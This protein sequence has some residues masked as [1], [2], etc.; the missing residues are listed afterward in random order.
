M[1][2]LTHMGLVHSYT[3]NFN[4]YL[5]NHAHNTL[6]Y[7]FTGPMPADLDSIPMEMQTDYTKFAQASIAMSQI[8]GNPDFSSDKINFDYSNVLNYVAVKTHKFFPALNKWVLSHSVLTQSRTH[9]GVENWVKNVEPGD[10]LGDTTDGLMRCQSWEVQEMRDV[11]AMDV[12]RYSPSQQ[13][14]RSNNFN[15]MLSRYP[16]RYP[17]VFI[18]D[19]PTT[20]DSMLI[21]PGSN[22]SGYMSAHY[23]FQYW[24]EVNQVWVDMERLSITQATTQAQLVSFSQ[25][26]T[27][28]KFKL[29]MS[30][31][32]NADPYLY[33]I[34]LCSGTEPTYGTGLTDITWAAQVISVKP[35]P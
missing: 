23:D 30:D 24:D 21:S 19:Q 7:F 8:Q 4:H 10:T 27:S 6:I 14:Y 18:Y 25:S 2:N 20:V 17:M 28:T 3:N 16:Y 15:T 31:T 13:W 34:H 35:V 32:G 5:S 1:Y 33:Y 22:S 9:E 29:R 11:H 12:L 26:Y